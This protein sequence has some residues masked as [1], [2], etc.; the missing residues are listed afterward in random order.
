ME[1]RERVD[2]LRVEV[3]LRFCRVDAQSLLRLWLD[4]SQP[5]GFERLRAI[6]PPGVDTA[7]EQAAVG[8]VPVQRASVA[9]EGIVCRPVAEEVASVGQLAPVVPA[10]LQDGPDGDHQ[11]HAECM[12]LLGHAAGVREPPG[13]QRLLAPQVTGPGLPV[14]H[15]AVE[16]QPELPISTG[17]VEQLRLAGV[18]LLRLDVAEGPLRGHRRST[19]ELT[20][21]R[22]D[23]VELGADDEVVVQLLVDIGPEIGAECVVVEGHQGRAVDEDAVAAR[24]DEHGNRGFHVLLVEELVLAAEVEHALFVGAQPVECLAVSPFELELGVE[25]PAVDHLAHVERVESQAVRV[26]AAVDGRG[27]VE[28]RDRHIDGLER[29]AAPRWLPGQQSA[30][31]V[32]IREGAGPAVDLDRQ[33][34]CADDQVGRPVCDVEADGRRARPILGHGEA[35]LGAQVTR[36]RVADPDGPGCAGLDREEAAIRAH[37]QSSLVDLVAEDPHACL[38]GRRPATRHP[39]DRCPGGRPRPRRGR[40]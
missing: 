15:D 4:R 8:L 3:A 34:V 38:H 27:L 6:R 21:L 14:E 40:M 22:D 24:R 10:R 31:P 25:R 26:R 35:R 23:V 12:Q 5:V 32:E 19:G 30:S 28:D 33:G 17:D 37:G 20:E 7:G 13:V 16:R 11:P 36:L 39:G 29:L 2:D 1:Q 9:V 18:A